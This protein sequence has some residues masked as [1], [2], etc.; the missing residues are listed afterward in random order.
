MKKEG[1][2]TVI[3]T[4]MALVLGAVA[5]AGDAPSVNLNWYGYFKLDGAYD[6]NP[7][8]HGNFVMWIPQASAY[9]DNAQFSMTANETRLGLNATGAGYGNVTVGGKLEVDLYASITGAAIAENKAMLQ[10]RHA[11]FSLEKNSFKVIAGQTWDIISPLNPSTLNYTV[12]W[13]CGNTGYRRPQ[14][15]FW[16][17]AKPSKTTDVVMAGGVFRTIGNDLTPTFTLATGEATDGVDDGTDA[18]MPSFQALVDVKHATANGGV[19]RGGLSAL[20]G[21]M[22]AETNRGRSE[23]YSSWGVVGHAAISPSARFGFSGELFTGSNLGSYFGGILRN[24]EIDGLK[25]TG[26]WVSSWV[27]ASK[28][29]QL[30]AGYGLDDPKDDQITSG[31]TKNSCFYGNVRYTLV[32]KATIGLELARW[33]TDYKGAGGSDDVRAQTSFILGF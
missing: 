22:K 23:N 6:Q 14:V 16:Y 11:Y 30:S 3:V 13:G 28:K 32:P 27:Q 2:L 21:S 29:V 33:Q 19:Y 4:S 31:R 26:G 12:L 24:S 25:T 20:Y 10:L 8:S 17:T 5:V 18:A 15:S 9:G 1:I 7:T